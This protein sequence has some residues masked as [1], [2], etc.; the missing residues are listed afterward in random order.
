MKSLLLGMILISVV[1]AMPAFAGKHSNARV[2]EENCNKI[3]I[4]APFSLHTKRLEVFLLTD[5]DAQ[6]IH[7]ISHNPEIAK[8]DPPQDFAFTQ[9]QLRLNG[10][11]TDGIIRLIFGIRFK[12]TLV[13]QVNIFANTRRPTIAYL[14]YSLLPEYWGKKITTEAVQEV[15]RYLKSKSP[16][17]F[18][19][20]E[21][22]TLQK[23]ER[24]VRL[25]KGLGF[26]VMKTDGDTFMFEKSL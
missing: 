1:L 10:R 15:L 26:Q 22:E 6:Q 19:R 25:L 20:V 9:E 17:R 7:D 23:N 2:K 8:T 16:I 3:L 11:E 14:G 12:G 5:A 18:T 21:A 24:S 4:K 13:G